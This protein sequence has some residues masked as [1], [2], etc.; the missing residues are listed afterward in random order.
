MDPGREET[1]PSNVVESIPYLFAAVGY[2]SAQY[3]LNSWP[4]TLVFEKAPF[5]II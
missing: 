1:N 2:C 4:K 5:R 3:S